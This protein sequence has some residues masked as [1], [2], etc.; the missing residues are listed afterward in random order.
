M[1]D[2]MKDLG[3]KYSTISGITIS[4]SDV[5]TSDT[6]QEVIAEAKKTVET[7]NKQ[8]NRGLITNEER[9]SKVIATWDAD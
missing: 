1:L 8:Y 4:I 7:I 5:V 9:F 3:F 6:K 2:K